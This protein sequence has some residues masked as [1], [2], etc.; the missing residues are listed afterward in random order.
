MRIVVLAGGIGGARFLVGVRAYAREVGA[1]VTAVVN[2]G[3]DASM[4]GLRICP[5]LDSVMYTLGGG[6]DPERGWGRVGETWTVKGELAAYG[7]E[8]TWFGLGDKDVA[9]HLVRSTMLTAGYPL[10]AVTEALCDRWQPGVRLIPASDDRLETHAVVQLDGEQKA[11]HFQEWWVRHRGN[12]P[13]ERFVFVGAESA[14]PAPGVLDALAAADVVM[15]AP[16]NPVVS[17]API[18]AVPGLREAVATGTA[19]VV[20]IS[21][22]IGGAPVRGMADKCL[23]IVGAECTAAGVGGLYGADLL[24]GWLVDTTDEGAEVPGV[25]VRAVPLWMSDEQA[26]TTM[27]RAAM[28]LA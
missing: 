1:E 16:S 12:L 25:A 24:D 14:K 27:V 4:H 19:P 2:V 9:T 18:L 15:L 3:D 13:T 28:E 8:P 26:T 5:D 20:G 17:I 11:I 10:S 6:A 7:A 22:I 21:P 23:A